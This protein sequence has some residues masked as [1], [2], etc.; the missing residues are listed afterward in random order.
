VQEELGDVL[1]MC[2][3]YARQLGIDPEHAVADKWFRYERQPEG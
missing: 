1:G 2:L 3:V